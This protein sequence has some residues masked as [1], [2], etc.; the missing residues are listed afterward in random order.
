MRKFESIAEFQL[1]RM[2]F[3]PCTTMG[4]L[5]VSLPRT[6]PPSTLLRFG[7]EIGKGAW[8]RECA[9]LN[10]IFLSAPH[11]EGRKQEKMEVRIG[12]LVSTWAK[13][14]GVEV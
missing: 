4:R 9:G 11:G 14:D 2:P 1:W 13:G 3:H 10:N 7:M 5:T 8:G 12:C 6:E